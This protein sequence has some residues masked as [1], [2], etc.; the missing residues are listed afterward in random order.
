LVDKVKDRRLVIIGASGVIGGALQEAARSA[1][2]GTIGTALT[3]TGNGLVP[4]DMRAAPVRSVVADL[5]PHDVV[6]LLAG[7]ASPAWI[8]S[9]PDAAKHVNLDCSKRIVD[10]VDAA[11]A[12][13]VFMS[14]D[15]V[16]D[17]Q[18]GGYVETSAPCP[19][20]L[21]GRLK[22]AMEAHILDTEKGIVVRTG[23]NV[24]WAQNRHCAVSQCYET[25][26]KPNARMAGDNYFNV[27]DVEDTARGLLAIATSVSPAHRIY[28]LV[29]TP[30]IA[31]VELARI[32]KETSV[33][34]GAMDYEVVP[35]ASIAYSEPRPTRAFL[36]SANAN[37]LVRG[38]APPA[39]VIRR[40]VA[41]LDRWRTEARTPIHTGLRS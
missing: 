38:F 16:F 24:A 6:V 35:F 17:G 30:E 25:L 5:G 22:A 33:W 7:Y 19:V 36:R 34:G 40:K 26:L 27:T 31:R 41:L 10:E 18:T 39:D 12:R 28:H 37:D 8:F 13:L 2:V 23:W 3:K 9:N 21:Y 15:Q 4:F 20:N 32:V 11:G 1:G 29:S 14:T